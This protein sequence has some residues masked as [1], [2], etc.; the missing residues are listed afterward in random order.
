MLALALGLF[1]VA[2][3]DGWGWQPKSVLPDEPA[4][5]LVI[6]PHVAGFGLA[7]DYIFVQDLS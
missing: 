3:K 5:G 1:S 6:L 7:L 2:I 4:R